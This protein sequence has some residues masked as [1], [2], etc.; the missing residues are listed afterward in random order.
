MERAAGSGCDGTTVSFR[1]PDPDQKHA[2]VRVL[3]GFLGDPALVLDPVGRRWELTIP[4]PAAARIEYKLETTDRAGHVE[5]ICDPG[6]PLRAPG[7]FGDSS[8]LRC[9][10]YRAPD[11]LDLPPAPGDWH[12]LT[13]PT[14]RLRTD[15]TAR[16][17]SPATSTNRILVAHDG[18]DYDRYGELGKYA[19][20][21]IAAGRVPPFHLVLLPAGDRFEWYSCSPTYARALGRD[22]LPKLLAELGAS[23]PVVG[24]GAS[25]GALAMLYAHRRLPGRFA[26]LFLQSG[27]FFQPRLDAQEAGFSRFP[28]IVR[29]VSRVRHGVAR[30][31]LPVALT[32]GSVE[33]NLA[34]N[35][36]MADALRSSGYP[37]TFA[38]NPDAH[39]W[40]G[41]RDTFDPHLTHLLQRVWAD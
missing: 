1:L 23:A 41:W 2:A 30:D 6:N 13:L 26:G 32:C 20:A 14:P 38:E 35:R 3:G 22:I 10:G 12:D 27:S 39:T 40:I 7:G 37:V 5:I 28:R 8:E 36:S 33:E 34:N 15:L 9:P 21:S 25:L 31:P 16:I 18:P 4:R 24:A 11:W 29:F 17:W 19:A